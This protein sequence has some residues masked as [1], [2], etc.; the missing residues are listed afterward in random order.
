MIAELIL[1]LIIENTVF[2][3]GAFREPRASEITQYFGRC[4]VSKELPET[5][6]LYSWNML[7]GMKKEWSKGFNEYSTNTNLF[8]LQETFFNEAQKKIFNA[9]AFCWTAGNAHVHIKTNVASGVATGTYTKPIKTE[10]TYS[11]Y[12]EPVMWVRQSTLYSWYKIKKSKKNLLVVNVHAINFVPDYMYFEQIA[13]IEKKLRKHQGP[14]IL[15]GDFNSFS[16]SKTKFLNLLVK[17][18]KLTEI[19]FSNDRRKKFRSFPL[20]HLFVRGFTALESHVE[21]S[22]L[23]SDHNALWARLKLQ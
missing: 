4:N 7:T 20:D 11:K 6:D 12:Y 9:S 8:L 22:S 3:K 5:I 2:A 19:E 10:V 14:L 21:D 13:N 23:S 17:K 18:H 1:K 15:A 16:L